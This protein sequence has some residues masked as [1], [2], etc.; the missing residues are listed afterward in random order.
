MTYRE[1]TIDELAG[2]LREAE[3]AVHWAAYRKYAL[4]LYGEKAYKIVTATGAE[5]ND[6]TYDDKVEFV[7][8]FDSDGNE[9]EFDLSTSFWLPKIEE[10]NL[11]VLRNHL[12]Y[13]TRY[14][15]AAAF[16][17]NEVE[18]DVRQVLPT[19]KNDGTEFT[20]FVNSPPKFPRIAI[21]ED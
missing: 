4:D 18:Y 9:L 21:I 6:E 12:G 19:L 5:Y 14:P 17:A 16:D 3:S 10:H 8:V 7:F 20:F 15:Y 11:D 13:Y 1:L 2:V